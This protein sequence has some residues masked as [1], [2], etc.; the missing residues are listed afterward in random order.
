M[1]ADFKKYLTK[2]A[3]LTA[4]DKVLVA[5]SG[6]ADSMVL[7]HLLLSA[8]YTCSVAHANFGLRTTES[9]QDERFVKTLADRY[10]IRCFIKKFDT[11]A[12]K[13]ANKQSTQMA[14]REL[15][16]EWFRELAAQYSFDAIATG[17]HQDDQVESFFINLLR[18]AGLKGLKA[19]EARNGL[20]IRPL[21][22]ASRNQIE[23]YANANGIA[24][25]NDSSNQSLKYQRNQIRHQLIPVLH[26]IDPKAP[27]AVLKSIELL[28]Q[29]NALYQELVAKSVQQIIHVSPDCISFNIKDLQSFKNWQVLLWEL[30]APYGF[31]SKQLK[32]IAAAIGKISG[33]KFFSNSHRLVINRETID[34]T[35]IA[36]DSCNIH[37][38]INEGE[39][40]TDASINLHFESL[41]HDGNLIIDPAPSLAYVDKDK[42]VFPLVI[43]NWS[44]GDRFQP[45]GMKGK[46]L[47]SDYFTDA[48]FS[49]KQKEEARLLCNSNGDIIWLIGERIDHRY[50]ITK[51]TKTVLRIR[52]N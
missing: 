34:L 17:H 36:E 47:I 33:K 20:V 45:L 31:D 38:I 50:R 28:G 3:L 49:L 15:R 40:Y 12:Y 21:L 30:I 26:T 37:A 13:Q 41:F 18:G 35:P 19:M 23:L 39:G 8:G 25:R 27:E 6:G 7:L 52:V 16:Y 11:E 29:N 1:L 2:N 46:K 22:F 5:V 48:H 32:K 42:I 14:A 51:N 44:Q 43:R 24:F 4:S 9:D 10:Q